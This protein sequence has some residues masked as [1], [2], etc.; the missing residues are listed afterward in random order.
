MELPLEFRKRNKIKP[1]TAL[2]VTEV[3]DGLY[4]TPL[5]EPSEKQLREVITAAG[6]L[7]RRQTGTEEE[8]V[9]AM[10]QEYRDEKRRKR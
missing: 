10:I 1:G 8:M 2:R 4:V 3:G 5:G 6:S 7:T 9:R